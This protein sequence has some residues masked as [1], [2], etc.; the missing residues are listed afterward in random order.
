MTPQRIGQFVH[1]TIAVL[2]VALL[3]VL[4]GCTSPCAD[5]AERT[6]QRAGETD[7]VCLRL[8]TVA[9]QPTD[10][11]L[12]ACRAGQAFIYEMERR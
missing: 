6:C 9:Q 1:P 4:M 10:Q 8:R 5:L 2:A 7:P 12:Q 3:A 11:D